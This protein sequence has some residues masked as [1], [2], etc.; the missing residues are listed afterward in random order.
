MNNLNKDIGKRLKQVR[1]IMNEGSKLTAEQFAYLLGETRDKIANY[2]SGRAALPVRILYELFN[3]GISVEFILA[4][5][6]SIFADNEAG[7]I[8][9][10]KISDRKSKQ[11]KYSTNDV[12]VVKIKSS[13]T[14]LTNHLI[15]ENV[16]AGKIE[17]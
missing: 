6:G 5:T 15:I 2:E 13:D 11:K 12:K 16:A 7:K 17:G 4:G 10:S 14:H 1:E 3:R 8:F 9:E